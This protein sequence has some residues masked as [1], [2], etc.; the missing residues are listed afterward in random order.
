MNRP[1]ACL[2]VLCLV[3]ACG[4]GGGGAVVAAGDGGGA[5]ESLCGAVQLSATKTVA[6][7]STLTVCAGATVTLTSSAS[8]VVAGTLAIEGTASSPVK[9]SGTQA[10][11]GSWPGLVV[12]SGGALIGSFFEVHG[13]ALGI[14]AQAGSTFHIDHL[15]IDTTSQ[16][17]NLASSGTVSHGVLHGLGDGQNSPAIL[18]DSASPRVADTLVNQGAYDGV[19]LIVVEGSA[20]APVFDHVEVSDAH[21]AFHVDEGSGLTIS[22]AYLHHS[23]YGIMPSG[24]TGTVIAHTNFEDNSVNVG[25]CDTI[26]TG[27]LSGDFF[28]GPATD[29]SCQQFLITN[30]ATAAY[31]TDVGPRP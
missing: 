13:A 28:Q 1:S 18:V 5:G 11:E 4:G 15:L 24:S 25:S 17:L 2:G 8:I 12:R 21:C 26:A 10:T 30:A 14:D 22:N 23:A 27:E 7:G 6:A 29:D 19:D 31:T 20:S 9:L 16:A 3:G